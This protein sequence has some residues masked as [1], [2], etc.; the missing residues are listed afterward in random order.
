VGPPL[1]VSASPAE[2]VAFRDLDVD[3]DEEL[4]GRFHHDVLA[5][6]FTSDELEDVA[7]LAR[8]LRGNGD[9][10]VL[11]SVALGADDAVLGGAVGELYVNESVLLLAYLAVRPDLRGC[12]IGTAL[13]ERVAPL[14]YTRPAVRL[15][16]AEVHDPRGWSQVAGDDPARRLHLYERLGARLLAV[17][18]VQPTVGVGRARVPGFLLLAF[19]VDPKIEVRL[20]GGAAV[21]SDIVGAFVRQYFETAESVKAPYDAQLAELLGRIAERPAIPLLPVSEYDRIP[22][23]A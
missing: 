11:A 8:G 3:H 21:R 22:L 13:M 1:T 2:V 9:L 5:V 4:I 17:P 14:W 16:V 20:D 23:L 6:S 19:H 12:G 15:A 18:F 10:E 7:T